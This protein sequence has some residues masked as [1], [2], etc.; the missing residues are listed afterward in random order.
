MYAFN[1][2]N[3]FPSISEKKVSISGKVMLMPATLVA[4]SAD[5]VSVLSAALDSAAVVVVVSAAESSSSLV[6]ASALSAAAVV[7]AVEFTAD[8]SDLLSP[9]VSPQAA[10]DNAITAAAINAVV[11][12]FIAIY[13]LLIIRV[14]DTE[15]ASFIQCIDKY[16]PAVH[17]TIELLN[18]I[19]IDLFIPILSSLVL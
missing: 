4:S 2:S 19:I 1:S 15:R 18:I 14:S 3:V 5:E 9:D 13:L 16:A 12:L 6:F 7:S 11:L 8:L 10:R 17:L